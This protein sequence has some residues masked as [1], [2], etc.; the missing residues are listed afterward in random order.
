M[1]TTSATYQALLAA[2]A[3]KEVRIRIYSSSSSYTNYYSDKIVSANITAALFETADTI[4]NATAKQLN[5]VLRNYGTIPRM[6][7]IRVHF[8]LND[9]TTQSEWLP[10]GVFFIDTRDDGNGIISITAY[11]PMLKADTSYTTSGNQGGWPKTDLQVVQNICS[12]IGV[13]LDSRTQEI[14]TA[15]YQIQYPGYGEGAYTMREL[16]QWIAQMYAGNFYINDQNKLMLVGLGDFPPETNYLVTE[17]NDRILIG[18]HR[19]L[20]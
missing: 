3:P 9:G 1:Q 7:Q 4:G 14:M 16:L 15:G 6:A 17:A 10:K 8:R 2:G 19:I 11:D 20:V 18:G 12:R 13:T 5:L